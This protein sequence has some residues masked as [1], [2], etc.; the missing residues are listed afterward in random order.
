MNLKYINKSINNK[1]ILINLLNQLHQ[2]NV[3][4]NMVLIIKKQ[5]NFYLKLKAKPN[6]S[7]NKNIFYYFN[8]SY[9]SH[10]FGQINQYHKFVKSK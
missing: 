3:I 10:F 7:H 8:K 6:L 1:I 9:Q 4:K 2:L 5:I